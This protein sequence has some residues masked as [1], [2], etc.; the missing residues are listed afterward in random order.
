MGSHLALGFHAD[1]PRQEGLGWEEPLSGSNFSS[2]C[3]RFSGF[4]ELEE[5]SNQRDQ[6]FKRYK[7]TKR[8]K[9]HAGGDGGGIR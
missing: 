5:N 4:V 3:P 1:D 7:Q 2:E 8:V 9:P 6:V